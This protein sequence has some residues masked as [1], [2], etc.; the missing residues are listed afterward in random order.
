MYDLWLVGRGVHT[1]ACTDV[2]Q[3][4]QTHVFLNVS[5]KWRTNM[6]LPEH[7]TLNLLKYHGLR[8]AAFELMDNS[9]NR[10][11]EITL[12]KMEKCN[13]PLEPTCEIIC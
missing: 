4:K 7:H 11:S 6:Y 1:A 10:N 9:Q 5:S 2:T 12:R 8:S 3:F 13:T